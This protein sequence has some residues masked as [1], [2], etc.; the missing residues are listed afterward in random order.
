MGRFAA[1]TA[2]AVPPTLRGSASARRIA[3]A[4][5]A[6]AFVL[7]GCIVPR[8]KAAEPD[9][10]FAA[11]P[12]YRGLV[13]D[14][15]EGGQTAVLVPTRSGR[16]PGPTHLFQT[17]GQTIA[18]LWS[19]DHDH[20]AVRRT[21][22]VTAPLVGEVLASWQ[23]GAIHL[24]FQ[25]PD[26]VSFHT[27]GFQRIDSENFPHTL[28]REMFLVSDLPGVY[29]AEVRDRQ[30]APVGWLRVRILPYQG[31]PRDYEGDVPEPLNGPLA[32]AAVTLVDAEINSIVEHN[33]LPEDRLPEG[34]A[35]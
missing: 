26:G 14:R 2:R 18:A 30:N 31:L 4:V 35:P 13:V 32:A 23:R 6:A 33:A 11:H 20:V 17:D 7:H 29:R 3:P 12:G 15:M 16:A 21:S 25:S 34:L 8:S 19:I 22:D 28:D 5:F 24:A 1:W 9:A 27:S 10:D